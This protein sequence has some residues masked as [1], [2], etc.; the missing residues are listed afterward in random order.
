MGAAGPVGFLTVFVELDAEMFFEERRE[1][2]ALAPKQLG[3][4]HGVKKYF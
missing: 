3:G 1:P 2:D 4:E